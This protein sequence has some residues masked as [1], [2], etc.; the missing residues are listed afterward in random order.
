ME[1][2]IG[3]IAGIRMVA[4]PGWVSGNWAKKKNE[5][6]RARRRHSSCRA[7]YFALLRLLLERPRRPEA[8]IERPLRDEPERLEDLRVD[9]DRDVRAMVIFLFSP[10]WLE[11]A[12]RR[13]FRTFGDFR[14]AN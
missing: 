5:C 11:G 6:L 4:K 10:K 9:D 1:A 8:D 13:V 7:R 2:A 12:D 14:N 3:R